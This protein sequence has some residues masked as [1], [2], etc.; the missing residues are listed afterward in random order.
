MTDELDNLSNL[1]QEFTNATGVYIGKLIPPKKE[2]GENDDDRAH[3]DE[4][5]PKVIM[6]LHA[7][8]GHEFM[9]ERV[10][11]P[12]DGVLTHE[13]FKDKEPVNYEQ[14]EEEDPN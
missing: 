1:L 13:V 2:I 8:K 14:Q 6:F 9:V 12:S 10:L 3:I 7:S 5:N 4:D 11:K